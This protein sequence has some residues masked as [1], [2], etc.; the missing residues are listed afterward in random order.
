MLKRLSGLGRNKAEAVDA[1]S[2]ARKVASSAPPSRTMRTSKTSPRASAAPK[3]K[4]PASTS[5]KHG[6]DTALATA[7]KRTRKSSTN[8]A[9]ATELAPAVAI[10]LLDKSELAPGAPPA[11]LDCLAAGVSASPTKGKV[12][13]QLM[14]DNGAILPVE[15]SIAA[16]EALSNGLAEELPAPK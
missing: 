16:G 1:S 4:P 13:V 5:K 9:I 6:H 15:M 2:R 7:R 11:A 8:V 3:V 12:R 14:F 10:A